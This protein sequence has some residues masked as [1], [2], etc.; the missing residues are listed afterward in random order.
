MRIMVASPAYGGVITQQYFM[1][2]F[3][4]VVEAAQIGWQVGSFVLGNESLIPRGRNRCA[5]AALRGGW[6]KLFFID[7]DIGWK[8]EDFKKVAEA[9]VEI[10]G[11]AVPIKAYPISL[12]FN[13]LPEDQE[14]FEGTSRP[15][16]VLNH[17]M[18]M[19][20]GN[21]IVPVRHL[22]TAFLCIDAKVLKA[23]AINE[24][25]FVYD[26]YST[27]NLIDMWDL[28]PI[29]PAGD[30]SGNR[31]YMSEDW[32]FCNIA[33]DA[34]FKTHVHAEVICSHTGS[35]TFRGDK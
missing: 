13:P 16:S 28:F 33:A 18:T 23:L 4:T 3:H 22:G 7:A 14:Y 11:G 19:H 29:G 24:R 9:P 20:G 1:S 31:V 15:P 30:T 35:H 21:P 17:L 25:R 2:F 5:A 32:G 10:C 27:G 34:G 26:D 12:N 6:D 8:W